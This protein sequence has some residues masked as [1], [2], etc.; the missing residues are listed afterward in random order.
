MNSIL[1]RYLRVLLIL[2]LTQSLVSCISAK[3]APPLEE[4]RLFL[5]SSDTTLL[6]GDGSDQLPNSTVIRSRIAKLNTVGVTNVLGSDDL[7][8][9]FNLFDDAEYQVA[10]VGRSSTKYGAEIWDGF[11]HLGDSAEQIR[12]AK[13]SNSITGSI[14]ISG[15][16]YEIKPIG[17]GPNHIVTELDVNTD[18]RDE[19]EAGYSKMLRDSPTTSGA[20]PLVST[21]LCTDGPDP[22]IPIP[23]KKIDV[24]FMVAWGSTLNASQNMPLMSASMMSNIQ[25]AMNSLE[26][27]HFIQ[28]NLVWQGVVNLDLSLN[29]GSTPALDAVIAD[30]QIKQIRNNSNADLVLY[31]SNGLSD[32]C[33][34]GQLNEYANPS[35]LERAYSVISSNCALSGTPAHE[36]GHLIGMRHDRYVDHSRG[37]GF[38]FGFSNLAV[39]LRT[40]MAYSNYCT[41][42]GTSCIRINRYSSPR[43]I[44]VSDPNTKK[45][46]WVKMGIKKGSPSAAHNEELLCKNINVIS[47]FR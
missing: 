8:I 29:T 15:K 7:D 47:R 20:A 6:V 31:I 18:D 25:R 5:D 27:T 16:L 4:I 12:I 13:D 1:T 36:V 26:L 22:G 2:I 21:K 30:T 24:D 40:L 3:Q 37:T 46:V 14:Q 17:S 41:D 33:G 43:E 44:A 19:S 39:K 32:A 11:H 9:I 42:S 10:N 35:H 28:A 45:L 34:I 38:N 23:I